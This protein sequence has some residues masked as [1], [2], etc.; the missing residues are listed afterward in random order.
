MKGIFLS[1]LG[2]VAGL[3]LFSLLS[4]VACDGIS[5]GLFWRDA[6]LLGVSYAYAGEES[7]YGGSQGGTYGEKQRVNTKADAKKLLNDYFSKKDVS[8]GRIRERQYYFEADVL[9]SK[10]KVVD[11]VIVDK[12]T[13]RIRSIY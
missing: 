8:I 7:P 11:K 6:A 10:G 12:R 2:A 5:Q 4:G 9:D 3:L 13:G 1:C